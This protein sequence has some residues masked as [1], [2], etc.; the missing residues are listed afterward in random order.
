LGR[1]CGW[2]VGARVQAGCSFENHDRAEMFNADGRR[3]WDRQRDG[4]AALRVIHAL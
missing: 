4:R 1:R 2:S 3:G